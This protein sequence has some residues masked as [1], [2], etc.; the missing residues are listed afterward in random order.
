MKT[1]A[2]LA[3]YPMA[4]DGTYFDNLTGIRLAT[5][6]R[7]SLMLIAA[8][9]AAGCVDLSGGCG[10]DLLDELAAPGGQYRAVVFQRSCG[11]TTGFSTQVSILPIDA[12]LP[13]SGGNVFIADTD[14][15]NAPAGVGG[16]PRVGIRWLAADS[17]E[18]RYDSRARVFAI[19]SRYS[20]IG[21]QFVVDSTDYLKDREAMH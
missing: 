15:G 20:G 17:L 14:H 12:V 11:A 19:E 2:G 18:V 5:I 6:E 9:A 3:A 1:L 13:D 4:L 21:V 7:T 16:G 8:I 10:N